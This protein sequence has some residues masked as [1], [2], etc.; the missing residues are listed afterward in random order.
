MNF[1]SGTPDLDRALAALAPLKRSSRK[2]ERVVPLPRSASSAKETTRNGAGDEMARG[3]SEQAKPKAS[4]PAK[5]RHRNITVLKASDGSLSYRVQFRFRKNGK[6]ISKAR[7]FSTLKTAK[8]WRDKTRADIEL[9]GISLPATDVQTVSQAIKRRLAVQSVLRRWMREAA[10]APSS[11]FPGHG[12]QRAELAEIAALKK[13][14][15]KLKAERDILKKGRHWSAIGPSDNGDA[16]F[17][18]EAT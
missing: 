16:F 18:R 6:Q 8:A 14:V 12:Q 2:A 7:S 9:H 3:E 10:A 4:K 5:A 1:T 15:A 17:A 13:E 11:A